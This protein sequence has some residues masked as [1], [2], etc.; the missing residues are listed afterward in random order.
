MSKSNAAC[1][2]SEGSSGQLLIQYSSF[3]FRSE[4]ERWDVT[5]AGVSPSDSLP[6]GRLY[7]R[8]TLIQG[9]SRLETSVYFPKR[10]G[11]RRALTSVV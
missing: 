8:D 9:D 10:K 1:G 4:V 5:S 2:P 6:Q 3:Y 7:K 11:K